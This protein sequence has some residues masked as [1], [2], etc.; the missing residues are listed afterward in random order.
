VRKLLM[1]LFHFATNVKREV[2]QLEVNSLF[3][4]IAGAAQDKT[5]GDC[6]RRL[7][8]RRNLEKVNTQFVSAIEL[9]NLDNILTGWTHR[10]GL[11]RRI[12]RE[13]HHEL[14]GRG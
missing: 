5:T 6:N 13:V 12:R 7:Q 2:Q 4:F 9:R 11:A 10:I 8:H 1:F 14:T 3:L